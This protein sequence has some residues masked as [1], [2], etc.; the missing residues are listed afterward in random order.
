MQDSSTH[1]G[2]TPGFFSYHHCG[3]PHMSASS[4]AEHFSQFCAW[5]SCV[6]C[7]GYWRWPQLKRAEESQPVGVCMCGFFL[8]CF[9]LYFIHCPYC[10]LCCCFVCYIYAAAFCFLLYYCALLHFILYFIGFIAVHFIV[11][12]LSYSVVGER[13]K[14]G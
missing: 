12:C 3:C 13:G 5:F 7:Q 1:P 9:Y 11:S 14:G 4:F 2:H 6:Y 10:L 8:G